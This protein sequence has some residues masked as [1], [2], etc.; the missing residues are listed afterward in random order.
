MFQILNN[1]LPAEPK[2]NESVEQ[3]L[4][5]YH[6]TKRYGLMMKPEITILFRLPLFSHEGY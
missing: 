3:G 5:I 4:E 6:I 1:S 2:V